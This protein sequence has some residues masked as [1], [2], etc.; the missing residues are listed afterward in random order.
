MKRTRSMIVSIGWIMSVAACKDDSSPT[1]V[2]T[3]GAIAE[4]VPAEHDEVPGSSSGEGSLLAQAER[5]TAAALAKAPAE[6]LK[7]F[8]PDDPALSQQIVVYR[9]VT[10]SLLDQLADSMQAVELDGVSEVPAAKKKIADAIAP[11]RAD[12]PK[13]TGSTLAEWEANQAAF[14]VRIRD[15]GQMLQATLKDLDAIDKRNKASA[16]SSPTAN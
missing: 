1:Q 3:S 8:L 12:L 9:Q 2:A 16:M 5:A 10:L 6:R 14:K 4:A 13:L 15:M 11:I 7:G